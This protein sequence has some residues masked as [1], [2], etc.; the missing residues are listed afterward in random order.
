MQELRNELSGAQKAQIDLIKWKLI[1]IAPIGATGLGLTG[2]NNFPYV[3]L[4][5]CLVPLVC[6]YADIAYYQQSLII[7]VISKFFSLQEKTPT[8]SEY[9]KF[10]AAVNNLGKN[11][12]KGFK[13]EVRNFIIGA[14]DFN[15]VVIS[16]SSYFLSLLLITYSLFVKFDKCKSITWSNT[17]LSIL[18][19]GLLGLFFTY[20]LKKSYR[21]RKDRI[22]EFVI[23]K[24][25]E[26]IR[27]TQ[28]KSNK[29]NSADA[30]S[31]TTD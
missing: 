12:L 3:E 20:I 26:Y 7:F 13:P 24:N 23:D 18:L 17:W 4:I 22:N 1:L 5:L 28:I 15:Y 11:K 10:S 29:A 19:F 2:A 9:E 6:L 8:Y 14:F 16:G 30:K 25:G 31:R 21:I 27:K